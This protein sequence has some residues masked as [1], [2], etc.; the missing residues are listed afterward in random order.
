MHCTTTAKTDA[1]LWKHKLLRMVGVHVQPQRQI[2]L[3]L[4]EALVW[5]QTLRDV[6]KYSFNVLYFSKKLSLKHPLV[7]VNFSGISELFIQVYA[8]F[9]LRRRNFMF[10]FYSTDWSVLIHI[11]SRLASIYRSYRSFCVCGYWGCCHDSLH[12]H[13]RLSRHRSRSSEH[14]H[15][16][17]ST[18]M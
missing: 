13:F 18:V 3:R 17:F 11:S 1:I 5:R 14:D 10:T 12:I 8:Y 6:H 4:N 2:V 15:R 7:A 9:K 16:G